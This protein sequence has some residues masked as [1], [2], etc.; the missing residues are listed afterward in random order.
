[1]AFRTGHHR[2]AGLDHGA[3]GAD[4]VAH[5]ADGVGPGANEH[6]PAFLDALGKIGVF[7]KKAVAGV[8]GLGIGDFGG[9]NNGRHV[10]VAF[11]RR[12]RPD[13]HGFIGK[14]HVLGIAVGLGMHDHRLDAEFAAGALDAQRDLAAIGDQ[15]L[16]KHRCNQP[17]TNSGW[18]YSTGSPFSTRISLM[19]PDLSASISLSSFMASMMHRG[20]PSLTDWPTSTKGAAPGLGAR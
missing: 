4:L 10:Q 2:H 14:A 17:M 20:S 18:P 5:Q 19:T 11:A 1:S 7:G 3:L 16:F 9:R 6:K 13:A 15:D 8:D 12:R